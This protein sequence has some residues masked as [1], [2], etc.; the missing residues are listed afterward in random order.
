MVMVS[1]IIGQFKVWYFLLCGA[2]NLQNSRLDFRSHTVGDIG[3][4]PILYGH[5][6]ISL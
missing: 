6:S 3:C 2:N 1:S 5:T 4:V